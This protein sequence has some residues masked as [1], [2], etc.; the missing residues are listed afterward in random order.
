MA[1]KIRIHVGFTQDFGEELK[2]LSP[3]DVR[4]C[5]TERLG[6]DVVAPELLGRY[7]YIDC[8]VTDKADIETIRAK[9]EVDWVEIDTIM[10]AY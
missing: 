2:P 4:T 7:G 1:D 8:M 9:D 6:L 3:D 10:K 5:V